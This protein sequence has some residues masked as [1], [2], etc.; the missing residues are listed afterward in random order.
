MTAWL[1]SAGYHLRHLPEIHCR[2]L[3]RATSASAPHTK[4]VGRYRGESQ[5]ITHV[6]ITPPESRKSALCII[7]MTS[8][9]KVALVT[10]GTAGL[11]A[12]ICHNL[13]RSGFRLVRL[14][15]QFHLEL[16]AN[17]PSNRPSITPT[18]EIEPRS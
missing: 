13:A 12:A 10:A 14:H 17:L 9:Q 4:E 8:V 18:T 15:Q 5:Y 3:L 7:T 16:A 11:G 6:S 2:P 1:A